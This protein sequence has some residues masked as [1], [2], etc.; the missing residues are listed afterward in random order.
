MKGFPRQKKRMLNRKYTYGELLQEAQNRKLLAKG[1]KRG[2]SV[3]SSSFHLI[4]MTKTKTKPQAWPKTKTKLDQ[5]RHQWVLNIGHFV[6]TVWFLVMEVPCV[7]KRPLPCFLSLLSQSLICYLRILLTWER[8]CR[9]CQHF[10]SYRVL[11]PDS[12]ALL[13]GRPKK[14]YWRSEPD[15]CHNILLSS[16]LRHHCC[17][18]VVTEAELA[19]QGVGVVA[20]GWAT[21]IQLAFSE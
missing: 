19:V 5:N 12:I 7:A 9:L 6:P 10:S 14:G 3:A 17:R 15:I 13:L 1:A 20:A 16:Q 11:W 2:P 18:V 8:K 4:E 21:E